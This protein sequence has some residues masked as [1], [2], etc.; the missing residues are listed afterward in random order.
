MDTETSVESAFGGDHVRAKTAPVDSSS[1]DRQRADD[2]QRGRL[3]K[4]REQEKVYD[5]NLVAKTIPEYEP[6]EDQYLQNYFTTPSIRKHLEKLGIINHEGVI[7][8]PVTFKYAQLSLDRK[9]RQL[10]LERMAEQRDMDRELEVAIRGASSRSRTASPRKLASIDEHKLPYFPQTPGFIVQDTRPGSPSER[11]RKSRKRSLSAPAQKHDVFLAPHAQIAEARKERYQTK[12]GTS[13]VS[14]FGGEDGDKFASQDQQP[15]RPRSAYQKVHGRRPSQDNSQNGDPVDE[16][17][18]YSDE[19]FENDMASE[20]SRGG[21]RAVSSAS[22]ERA[23]GKP[24]AKQGSALSSRSPSIKDKMG[25][26]SSSPS[27]RKLASEHREFATSVDARITEVGR[28]Q[29]PQRDQQTQM[30]N[31]DLRNT[32]DNSR[33]KEFEHELIRGQQQLAIGEAGKALL[34]LTAV[35]GEMEP[36]VLDERSTMGGYLAEAYLY[37]SKAFYALHQRQECDNA[38]LIAFKK[39]HHH[40]E[41]LRELVKF[42]HM[43]LEEEERNETK[44]SADNAAVEEAIE[45]GE[46][47]R[48]ERALLN[49]VK[50]L[51]GDLG[52]A[53]RLPTTSVRGSQKL[54]SA[55]ALSQSAEQSR[56]TSDTADSKGNLSRSPSRQSS[57]QSQPRLKA[58]SSPYLKSNEDSLAKAL[59]ASSKKLAGSSKSVAQ[60]EPEKPNAKQASSSVVELATNPTST[61]PPE[62]VF[63]STAVLS[64]QTKLASHAAL[65]RPTLAQSQP[66]IS[67]QPEPDATPLMEAQEAPVADAVNPA[68]VPLPASVAASAALLRSTAAS[69]QAVHPDQTAETDQVAVS[70][71]DPAGIALPPSAAA[72]TMLSQQQLQQQQQQST[73]SLASSTQESAVDPAQVPLPASMAASQM[74]LTRHASEASA[75][76]PTGIPLPASVAASSALLGGQLQSSSNSQ[77]DVNTVDPASVPLPMSTAPSLSNVAS[78]NDIRRSQLIRPSQH[79]LPPV[80]E[81]GTAHAASIALPES[82]AGSS[83]V[84]SGT[85]DPA[86]VPLP[87]SMAGS[88][89]SVGGHAPHRASQSLRFSDPV[90]AVDP[91]NVPLPP[92]TL[93]STASL[94]VLRSSSRHASQPLPGSESQSSVLDAAGIPLPPSVAGSTMLQ[95]ERGS[96]YASQAAIPEDEAI[97]PAIIALPPTVLNSMASLGGQLQSSHHASQSMSERYDEGEEVN[98]ADVPLPAS[99]AGSRMLVS[100]RQSQYASQGLQRD[101]SDADPASVPLPPSMAASQAL[102]PGSRYASQA[103]SHSDSARTVDAANVPLPASIAGSRMLLNDRASHHASQAAVGGESSEDVFDPA[104]IPLPPSTAASQMLRSGSRSSHTSQHMQQQ[105]EEAEVDPAGIPLPQSVAASQMLRSGSRSL[106]TSQYM[107]QQQQQQQQETEVNPAGV[108]LPVSVAASQ[109]L[110]PGSRYAS[111]ALSHSD[112]SQS[113][114]P[115]TVP[116]PASVA[117]S[118]ML[119]NDRPSRYASQALQNQNEDIL[120]PASVPLPQSV[121]ASQMLRSGLQSSHASQHIQSQQEEEA[122]EVDPAGVPLPQSVAASQMLHSGTRSLHA[123]QHMQ[124]RQQQETEIDPA[125]VPLP[126]STLQSTASLA[127]LRSASRYAS[128]SLPAQE[129]EAEVNAA[130]IALPQSVASSRMLLHE[131]TSRHASQAL[132]TDAEVDPAGVP[133]PSS[134]FQSTASLSA[135]RSASHSVSQTLAPTASAASPQVEPLGVLPPAAPVSEEDDSHGQTA[136]VEANRE[137][138]AL[139]PANVPLPASVAGS[140]AALGRL[141]DTQEDSLLPAS[142]RLQDDADMGQEDPPQETDTFDVNPASVPLPESVRASAADIRGTP[143]RR[144]SIPAPSANAPDSVFESFAETSAV[145]PASV[146]LPASRPGSV[147]ASTSDVRGASR[148]SSHSNVSAAASAASE[149]KEKSPRGASA[150]SSKAPSRSPSKASSLSTLNRPLQGSQ[151][152]LQRDNTPAEGAQPALRSDSVQAL[153]GKKATHQS[154]QNLRKKAASNAALSSRAASKS[155]SLNNLKSSSSPE[156]AKSAQGLATPKQQSTSAAALATASN[157]PLPPS[158]AASQ[159]ALG[160]SQSPKS[161][162]ASDARLAQDPAQIPLPASVAGSLQVLNDS[163]RQSHSQLPAG[164]APTALQSD[165]EQAEQKSIENRT[166]ADTEPASVAAGQSSLAPPSE[167]DAPPER[168]DSAQH[169]EGTQAELTNVDEETTAMED[170]SGPQVAERDEVDPAGIPLPASMATSLQM[171]NSQGYVDPQQPAADVPNPAD[172]PLPMSRALS[173]DSI[174]GSSA[175]LNTASLGN[176]AKRDALSG[177][178]CTSLLFTPFDLSL[179]PTAYTH[180]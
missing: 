171:L 177:S 180:A 71:V 152:A 69:K 178:S 137:Q 102:H 94:G 173:K 78:H 32:Q 88:T 40:P 79:Q 127:A 39:S 81:D 28:P 103:L 153:G 15:G 64:S 99:V 144:P 73:Q 75:V 146:P 35:L 89:M 167:L 92:S 128:Q 10:Y 97:N 159:N 9:E 111:Q 62:S 138:S 147:A 53:T 106:H 100:G 150:P 114:D 82:M 179:V 3:R 135:L 42:K 8:D 80:Y 136:D 118:R 168:S 141:N 74:L 133:L 43:L 38:L 91:S 161:V 34:T 108:P 120:D 83:T 172:V 115:A 46:Y 119:L 4:H 140:L 84:V 30:S 165:Q 132:S 6:L 13:G 166:V 29:S 107:Q 58:V 96:R 54:K 170:A 31:K 160:N 12:R 2:P 72:S 24:A 124:P 20:G 49:Y 55:E 67:N 47:N 98:P 27:R 110:R 116:L 125:G 18:G 163:A 169:A 50:S 16:F 61:A 65:S 76:D 25:S 158:V 112:S 7:T 59:K 176:I 126:P 142:N 104:G 17:H 36:L 157:T 77:G 85:F 139:D 87:P 41:V 57:A 37:Q 149:S 121:A 48:T 105:P 66:G 151:R 134:V 56:S 68:D 45:K 93:Q 86:G 60:S 109:S 101:V 123:S 155:A 131:R 90:E 26:M 117:G 175:K 145:D 162:F 154:A 143:Q 1:S 44:S 14:S 33:L 23:A 95:G 21:S 148:Q 129:A 113:V 164:D 130:Q 11:T 19:D 5:I 156:R 63:G 52:Q 174:A 22:I 122:A 70:E 51:G